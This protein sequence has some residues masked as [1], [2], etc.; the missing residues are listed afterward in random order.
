MAWN[1]LT[2]LAFRERDTENLGLFE[3]EEVTTK[4]ILGMF[5][6][7]NFGIIGAVHVSCHG[8]RR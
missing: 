8:G 2:W 5:F 7:G 1:D 6:G 3:C 4:S